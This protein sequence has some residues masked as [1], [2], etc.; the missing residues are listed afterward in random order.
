MNNFCGHSPPSVDSRKALVS[1]W[2]MYVHKV[3]INCLER[4]NPAQGKSE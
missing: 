3:L 1:Y 2:Q 4:S